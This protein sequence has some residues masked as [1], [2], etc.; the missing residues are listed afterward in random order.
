MP[1]VVKANMSRRPSARPT[2][3]APPPGTFSW[4]TVHEITSGEAIAI[5]A[6]TQSGAFIYT[7]TRSGI[8][9]WNAADGRC[10]HCDNASFQR[11]LLR[12]GAVQRGSPRPC[13][14]R[15]ALVT[16][17]H[18]APRSD[19]GGVVK[20]AQ[21]VPESACLTLLL[22]DAWRRPAAPSTSSRRQ[23]C[24]APSTP[25]S[26]A[27]R[28]CGAAWPTGTSTSSMRTGRAASAKRCFRRTRARSCA[29]WR[30]PAAT[31]S[32]PAALTSRCGVCTLM[33]EKESCGCGTR[34]VTGVLIALTLVV[35]AATGLVSEDL[36]LCQS[37]GCWQRSA[38]CPRGWLAG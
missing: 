9:R 23:P 33:E 37:C 1:I 31:T 38:G 5:K 22:A 2:S 11:H 16:A 29:R 4:A 19:L 35:P 20:R 8:R 12:A 24:P 27:A 32:S 36:V 15:G 3:S 25:W 6:A 34:A 17:A 13:P 21:T 14:A 28:T 26:C 30:G 10:V 18:C 7:S